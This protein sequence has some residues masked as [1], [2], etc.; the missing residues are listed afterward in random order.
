[1]TTSNLKQNADYTHRYNTNSGRHGW[2]RLTPAYSV[3]VV[4][5]LINQHAKTTRVL[6]PFCGTGTTALCS[7][8]RGIN[9]VTTDINPFLVW[10]AKTKTANYSSNLTEKAL[11]FASS[12]VS[13]KE[14]REAM[15]APNIYNIERWWT[16]KTVKFL[17]HLRSSIE[18]SSMKEKI[19]DILK[20]AFCRA[21]I[22][23]SN[24]SFNHQSMSFKVNQTELNVTSDNST[25]F[26]GEVK[27]VIRACNTK[28]ENL[29]KVQLMDARRLCPKRIGYFDL[30]VTSPPYANRM[31][32]V[33]ELRPYMYWLGY[34]STPTDAGELDWKAIGGTWGIATSRLGQWTSTNAYENEHLNECVRK[35]SLA[36]NKNALILSRYV[37]KYHDDVH[38][39]LASLVSVLNLGARVHYIV[40][41]SSFYGTLV[42]VEEIYADMLAKLGFSEIDIKPIRKRNSNKAL[43]EYDVS[44]TWKGRK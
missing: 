4:D 1:M 10:L 18:G 3:K 11:D 32:Y 12:I 42:K 21:L 19:R 40:G 13:T 5:E 35:I 44:A 27:Q 2:I 37:R 24:A 9:S 25:I 20:I 28:I 38:D 22:K 15:D 8:V 29:P 31:S 33:R 43:V 34:L 36:R 41:N 6:D 30:V 39:H 23:L 26:L 7:G 16:A 14:A 17:C